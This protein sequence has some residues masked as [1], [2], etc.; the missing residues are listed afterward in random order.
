MIELKKAINLN[1]RKYSNNLYKISLYNYSSNY[2]L[3]YANCE[4]DALD[5]LVDHL[6]E[7]KENGHIYTYEQLLNYGMTELEIDNNYVSCG[8]YSHYV[9]VEHLNIIEITE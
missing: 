3:V 1:D 7:I 4:Q 2:D 9:N 8:N 6:E 5:I